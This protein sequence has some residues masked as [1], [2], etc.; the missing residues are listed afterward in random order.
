M[1]GVGENTGAWDRT[2]LDRTTWWAAVQRVT[3]ESRRVLD[4]MKRS[5]LSL[6][7]SL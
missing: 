6:Q 7:L 1:M 4:I 3:S 5:C 2:G